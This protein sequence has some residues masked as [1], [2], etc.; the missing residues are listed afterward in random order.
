MFYFAEVICRINFQNLKLKIKEFD[1][2]LISS[3]KNYYPKS[4]AW[5]YS[6]NENSILIWWSK[7]I[8]FLKILNF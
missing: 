5:I 3:F 7:F 4:Y 8:N 6:C 1:S 2:I